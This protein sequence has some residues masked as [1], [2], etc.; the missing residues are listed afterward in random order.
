MHCK[1]TYPLLFLEFAGIISVRLLESAD[2]ITAV[3]IPH[4][5]CSFRYTELPTCQ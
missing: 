1:V 4:L 3:S 2:K 5:M